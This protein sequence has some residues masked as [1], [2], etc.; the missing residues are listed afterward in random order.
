MVWQIS[1]SQNLRFSPDSDTIWGRLTLLGMQCHCRQECTECTLTS[2]VLVSRRSLCWASRADRCQVCASALPWQ[3]RHAH[4]WLAC[5]CSLSPVVVSGDLSTSSTKRPQRRGRR[6]SIN[7]MQDD[8]SS[9]VKVHSVDSG[10]QNDKLRSDKSVVFLC[11]CHGSIYILYYH[12]IILLLKALND[13]YFIL[14]H[15]SSHTCP[16]AT[17]GMSHLKLLLG[18]RVI[19]GWYLYGL[20]RNPM[21]TTVVTSS[22]CY[23]R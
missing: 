19:R 21:S 8:T 20:P 12:R 17:K 13:A 22:F 2:P 14:Q 16:A 11:D 18:L 1:I 7:S 6:S 5:S 4:R 10:K 3:S 23:N 9:L 15:L